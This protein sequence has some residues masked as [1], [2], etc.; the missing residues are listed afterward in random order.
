MRTVGRFSISLVGAPAVAGAAVKAAARPIIGIMARYERSW[1]DVHAHVR[2]QKSSIW[3]KEYLSRGGAHDHG[4]S[5]VLPTGDS[6]IIDTGIPP[7][8]LNESCQVSSD[9]QG[10]PLRERLGQRCSVVNDGLTVTG[11][12]MASAIQAR[13][14]R[15]P[16]VGG[17]NLPALLSSASGRPSRRRRSVR[18]PSRHLDVERSLRGP[19]RL[20]RR[21][22][23]SAS[24]PRTSTT[25]SRS[26]RA[27]SST[28]PTADPA[29][30]TPGLH[31]QPVRLHGPVH[32]RR[33]RRRGARSVRLNET[34]TAAAW[35]TT[36]LSPPARSWGPARPAA[37]PTRTAQARRP[38]A[39]RIPA[40][41]ATRV[42]CGSNRMVL[43][44]VLL[45]KCASDLDCASATRATGLPHLWRGCRPWLAD[46]T[47]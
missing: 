15:R 46:A 24:T 8:L 47:A 11:S 35:S 39:A 13:L 28:T 42:L 26:P 33:N 25:S 16:P 22:R 12:C 6:G 5:G 17:F 14:L 36:Q 23:R 10:S 29:A 20:Y 1:R 2:L 32:P 44:V 40:G 4:G 18:L 38:R 27:A 19:P 7:R 41:R 34:R 45:L 31:Q 30:R 37:S 21:R 9:C 3:R 43:P